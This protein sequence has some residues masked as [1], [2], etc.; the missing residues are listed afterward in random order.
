LVD[1]ADKWRI[2]LGSLRNRRRLLKE[3]PAMSIGWLLF[4]RLARSLR[5]RTG[6]IAWDGCAGEAKVV[7]VLK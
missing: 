5:S 1:F 4:E 3:N 6:T 7:Y 2:P